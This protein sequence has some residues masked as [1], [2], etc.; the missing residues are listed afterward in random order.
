[1]AERPIRLEPRPSS[2]VLTFDIEPPNPESDFTL[3]VD[4][5]A[6]GDLP[7]PL[8]QIRFKPVQSTLRSEP[9]LR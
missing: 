5:L 1:V 8:L 9:S 7:V 4:G 3:R 2:F 6:W